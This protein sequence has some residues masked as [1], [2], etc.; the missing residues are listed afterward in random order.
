[1]GGVA[2][3]TLMDLK[4]SIT[5]KIVPS[6]FMIFVSK[7]NPFLANQYAKALGE[8]AI[9]GINKINSIYEPQQ[10]SLML[11]TSNTEALNILT[12]DVFDE[13]AEDY[14][15]F[16]NTIVICEQV[17]K[18]IT[19][20]VE[21]Y[22]IKFPKLEEWQL[23]DYAKTLCPSI[24]EE[25]IT[26]LV[27]TSGNSIERINNELDKVVLFNKNDQKEVFSAIRFDPQSDLYNVDLFAIVNA[28]ILGELG[29]LFEFVKHNGYNIHEPV[30]LANRAFSSLKNIILITQNPTLTAADCEI[31][32]GHYS[33]IKNKYRS[34]NLAAAKKK[35]KFLANFDLLLKTSQ[36]ELDKR[37]MLNYLIANLS[38]RII[39]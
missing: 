3:M 35:L 1:M 25:D 31:S 2:R 8:L 18:G 23:C 33:V 13:R 16:E 24:D 4:N 5:N 12:V 11:L 7:D 38:Y 27:K 37:D 6:D 36:L 14:S 10:S 28:L 32:T 26:W 22:V 20:N 34:I 15:Q 17:D 9:G 19:K 30:V 29:T 21:N 39:N